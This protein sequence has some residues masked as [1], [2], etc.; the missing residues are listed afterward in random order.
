MIKGKDDKK[1]SVR[2]KTTKINGAEDNGGFYMTSP[3][4]KFGK[5]G[6]DD[7]YDDVDSSD[8]P[9][10][11]IE[12]TL[13][14]GKP[15]EKD[16]RKLKKME[17]EENEFRKKFKFDGEINVIYTSTIIPTAST[18]KP[19]AKDLPVKPGEKVEII[20]S[21]DDTKVLCRNE[22][23]KYGYV[24]RSN[25]ENDGEIYDDIADSCIYDNN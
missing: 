16:A 2:E 17:K 3:E 19:G 1:K 15:D 21:T 12:V 10:P 25:L 13:G 22:D 8:F 18:K 6:G 11:P 5:D 4:K 14:R 7:V 24:L 9:P 20:Q 23:G